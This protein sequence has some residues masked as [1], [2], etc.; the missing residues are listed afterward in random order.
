MTTL[1][2]CRAAL[3]VFGDDLIPEELSRLFGH[4]YTQGW[5]KGYQ[6]STSSGAVVVKKTGAWILDAEPTESADFDDQISRLLADIDVSL[7]DWASLASRFEMDIFCGWF[8]QESNEGIEVSPQ[9]LRALGERNIALS[10]DIYAP[11][12]DD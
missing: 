11:L 2:R 8:M 4:F 10:V 9:T 6:Y 5:V 3:R 1:N 7:D 12:D